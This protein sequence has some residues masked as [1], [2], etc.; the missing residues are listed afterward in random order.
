MK[1]KIR[2]PSVLKEPSIEA[3]TVDVETVAATATPATSPEARA[4]SSLQ[5]CIMLDPT[6][7]HEVELQPLEVILAAS[8]AGDSGKSP[9]NLCLGKAMVP[10]GI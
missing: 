4:P 2:G 10:L 9:Q 1:L 8:S 3:G 7:I 6:S 5:C